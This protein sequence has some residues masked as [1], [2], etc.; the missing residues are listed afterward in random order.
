M[1]G[2]NEISQQL[3]GEAQIWAVVRNAFT[4]TVEAQKSPSSLTIETLRIE[5]PNR[6]ST[7]VRDTPQR[8]VKKKICA[9]FVAH[10]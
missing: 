4:W 8:T 3:C 5:L 6:L 2:V 1:P 7:Q 10:S 9:G